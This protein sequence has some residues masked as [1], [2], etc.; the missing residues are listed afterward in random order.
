MTH[1]QS[2]D[3]ES[4]ESIEPL[5]L[6]APVLRYQPGINSSGLHPLGR[7]VLIWPLETGLKTTKIHLP[8]TVK[9]RQL[10][11][12]TAG[13]VVEMGSE[14]YRDEGGV[15]CKVGD[16]VIIAAMSGSMRDGKDGVLYRFVNHRDVYGLVDLDHPMLSGGENA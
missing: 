6:P 11:L 7:A 1:L 12:D 16:P 14:C 3:L 10:I 13:W 8:D 4:P 9:Q 15:R 5:S 2:V